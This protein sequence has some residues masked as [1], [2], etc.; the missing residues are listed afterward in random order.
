MYAVGTGIALG[1][2]GLLFGLGLGLVC[3]DWYSISSFEGKP[4]FF[5]VAFLV[6]YLSAPPKG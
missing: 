3:V 1:I 6:A 4:G 2:A 5:V